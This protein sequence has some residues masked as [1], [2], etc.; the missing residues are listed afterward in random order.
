M[1]HTGATEDYARILSDMREE[2]NSGDEPEGQH[3]DGGGCEFEMAVVWRCVQCGR[4]QWQHVQDV[5][6]TGR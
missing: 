2:M 6:M 5:A 3:V 4:E 1:E